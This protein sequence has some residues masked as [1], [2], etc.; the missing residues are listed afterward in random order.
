MISEVAAHELWQKSPVPYTTL[1]SAYQI[2]VATA[3]GVVQVAPRPSPEGR[4]ITIT[5][6]MLKARHID[7]SFRPGPVG[8]LHILDAA[9]SVICVV[10][11]SACRIPAR[12]NA[13]IIP[14]LCQQGVPEHVIQNLQARTI[15]DGLEALLRPSVAFSDLKSDTRLKLAK[16]IQSNA[17][18]IYK[19]L[20]SDPIYDGYVRFRSRNGSTSF[21]DEFAVD[22]NLATTTDKTSDFTY[23]NLV[24]G[25][26]EQLYLAI[27]SGFDVMT[28]QY[29]IN[30]WKSLIEKA[31]K[32]VFANFN[33]NVDGSALVTMIPGLPLL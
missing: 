22:D 23:A 26:N 12:L 33:I 24:H 31:A 2:R 10:K 27:L 6:S 13:Q 8:G 32:S 30:S 21:M 11:A 25:K 17:N 15:E 28:S 20:I 9:H 3:K 4:W 7:R 29:F 5:S 18:L 19:I 14:I 16:T 1:P